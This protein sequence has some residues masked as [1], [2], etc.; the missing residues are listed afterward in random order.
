[1]RN[2]AGWRGGDRVA[3]GVSNVEY[4]LAALESVRGQ[5]RRGCGERAIEPPVPFPSVLAGILGTANGTEAFR[6]PF[7]ERERLVPFRTPFRTDRD[8][9]NCLKRQPFRVLGLRG[10]P[11]RSKS[12]ISGTG[13]E[14][15]RS[16]L[17]V[18]FR[19]AF[20]DGIG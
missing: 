15:G 8:A 13:T 19:T 2:H 11:V 10:R 17:P 4:I 7:L 6:S 14:N 18:P 20:R 12:G 5:M 9:R 16:V 1:M 3:P